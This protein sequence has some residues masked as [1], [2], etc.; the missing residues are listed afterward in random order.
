MGEEQ[1]PPPPASHC[2]YRLRCLSVVSVQSRF[3]CHRRG[4][5][6]GSNDRA[7]TEQ[8]TLVWGE[9]KGEVEEEEVV[10]EQHR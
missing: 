3:V 1:T 6:E 2:M 10:K 4:C 8:A 9:E 5:A 7:S